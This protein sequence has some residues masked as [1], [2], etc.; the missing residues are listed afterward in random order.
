MTPLE[1]GL[2]KVLTPIQKFIHDQTTSSILL[3][4]CAFAALVIANSPLS[5]S[6]E[7]VLD[8]PIGFLLGNQL[9]EMDLRHWINDGLMTLFFFVLGMEVKREVL[10]GEIAELERLVPVAAAAI[11]GM[12]V[13][14]LIFLSL[15]TGTPFAKGWGIPVATDTAFAIGILALL[16][17]RIP[18]SAFAFLTALAIIDDLG[19]ILIIAVFYSESISSSHLATSAFLLAALIVCNVVGVRKPS[20]YFLGGLLVWL[21]MLGSGVHATVAG[22]LVALTVPARAK[23]HPVS[24][25]QKASDLIHRFER[26]EQEKDSSSPMLEHV[27]QHDLADRVKTATE[28]ATTPLRR[29]EKALVHPVALFVLPIFALANAGIPLNAQVTG[30]LWSDT[31]AIGIVLGLCIGKGFGVPFFTWV[32]LRSGFGRLPKGLHM[33]HVVGLGLLGSVGFTMS[34][35]IGNLGFT[36]MPVASLTA[37]IGIVIASTIGGISGYLWLRFCR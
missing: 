27:E 16:G 34:I 35:F 21:A 3:M 14:A 32:A 31:L 7:E 20:V 6:Y 9:L 24:F 33:R 4:L 19:A 26:I 5:H 23:R 25:V 29:W 8:T 22:I 11:G 36:D 28:E 15:N 30:G 10:A 18:R 17:N 1:N 2:E 12:L 13:P 37:K